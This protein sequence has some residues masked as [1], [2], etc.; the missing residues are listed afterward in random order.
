[1]SY[2]AFQKQSSFAGVE[3]LCSTEIGNWKNWVCGNANL[4]V[5]VQ[6]DVGFIANIEEDRPLA[7]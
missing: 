4:R 3:Q 2:T 1:M 7:F 6:G 5:Y